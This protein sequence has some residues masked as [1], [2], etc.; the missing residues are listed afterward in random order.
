MVSILDHV[1]FN[2]GS[3]KSISHQ[4][5]VASGGHPLNANQ[6]R[7]LFGLTLC[8]RN[9]YN[10]MLLCERAHRVAT[11]KLSPIATPCGR[12]TVVAL[13]LTSMHPRSS[14]RRLCRR[15]RCVGVSW[16][17]HCVLIK[18]VGEKFPH[19]CYCVSRRTEWLHTSYLLLPHLV[20]D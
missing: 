10:V 12:L 20:V 7:G 4:T 2:L 18:G 16:L 3:I 9:L 1:F 14:R 8:P 19:V 11:Y 13:V 15:T 17:L 6:F 5:P